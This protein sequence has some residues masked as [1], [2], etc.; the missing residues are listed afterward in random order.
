MAFAFFAGGCFWGMEAV[1]QQIPGVIR[2]QVG[3][4]GG[5]TQDPT[6]QEVCSDS[7]GHAETVAIEF[8]DTKIQYHQLL[9]IFFSNHNPTELNRQG[10]DIGTQY[11]SVIFYTTDEQKNIAEKF[12]RDLEKSD[13]Y[14]KKIVTQVRPAP[15]FWPAEEYHQ[16]YF[17]KIAQRYGPGNL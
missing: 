1:F 2:T 8:D 17:Q 3:Y 6:Y 9:D 11:R 13:L 12:I 16:S 15:E 14:E 5:T 10:P 7:T 4:M